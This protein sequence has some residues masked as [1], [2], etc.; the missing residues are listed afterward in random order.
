MPISDFGSHDPEFSA[1][2]VAQCARIV[3]ALREIGTKV[4][5]LSGSV[6][7]LAAAAD[8]VEALSASLD[9]VTQSRAME[10]F[11]FQFDL[12]DPN[13]IMPFNPATG[14]FNPVA[15]NLDMKVEGE[16]LV[17]ELVFARRYESG[18]DLVQGGMVSALYDQLLAFAVM[19]HGKTGPSVSLEVKFLKRTPTEEPLRFE[20]WVE[21]IEGDR[22]RAR[23]VCRLGDTLIT[24]AEGLI[25]GKY[26]LPVAGK[27]EI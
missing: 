10:T 23:G 22:Y 14:A 3:N 19:I 13:T 25:I 20:T 5:R 24:E 15:P 17:T 4:V 12:N 21:E 8:R 1:D 26:D 16:R 18:P 9:A 11:R 2:Q 27:Q 7:E 6:E